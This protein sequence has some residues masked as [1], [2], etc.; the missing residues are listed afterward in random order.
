M[1][2]LPF[3]TPLEKQTQEQIIRPQE[4][5]VPCR[6]SPQAEGC[7]EGSKG[8]IEGEMALLSHIDLI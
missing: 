8:T 5:L 1:V 2:A 4:Q 6:E 3:D 7:L